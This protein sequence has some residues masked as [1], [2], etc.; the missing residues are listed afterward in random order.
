LI[1]ASKKKRDCEAS[2]NNFTGTFATKSSAAKS[3][4]SGH[5]IVV[6]PAQFTFNVTG[7]AAQFVCGSIVISKSTAASTPVAVAA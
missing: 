1:L 6:A 3:L 5:L 4:P 7:Q 2:K